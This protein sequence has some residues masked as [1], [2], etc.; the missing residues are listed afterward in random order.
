MPRLRIL[1]LVDVP[2]DLSDF[3]PDDYY[4]YEDA[5]RSRWGRL[6]AFLQRRRAAAALA[7]GDPLGRW[8][9]RR[10]GATPRLS[11]LR[12]LGMGFDASILDVG[13]GDGAL[14]QKL[15]RDGFR[16]LTGAD[17][18]LAAPADLGGAC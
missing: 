7:G 4:S 9:L 6:D 1:Q 2:E 15:Q 3:Y 5:R 14:L 13:C 17:P 12:T 8:L 10:Y 18:F 11:W 16:D